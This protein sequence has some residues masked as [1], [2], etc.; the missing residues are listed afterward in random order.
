MPFLATKTQKHEIP[1]KVSA[2]FVFLREKHH[3]HLIMV[4]NP[5]YFPCI[6][7]MRLVAASRSPTVRR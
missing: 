5:F 3:A 1:R 7:T 2:D 6:N 4:A